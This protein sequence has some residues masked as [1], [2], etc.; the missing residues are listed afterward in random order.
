MSI[1]YNAHQFLDAQLVI[2]MAGKSKRFFDAGYTKPKWLINV[3][4]KSILG[5]IIKNNEFFTKYKNSFVCNKNCFIKIKEYKKNF[6]NF[7]FR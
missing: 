3:F 5:H 6:I 1:K 4:D 7:T 2:P